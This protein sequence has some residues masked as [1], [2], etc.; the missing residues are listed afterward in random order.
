[1]PSRF[2]LAIGKVP[3]TPPKK[4]RN[5]IEGIGFGDP[6]QRQ[7]NF[8]TH[9]GLVNHLTGAEISLMTADF[10]LSI[11]SLPEGPGATI[12]I[13]LTCSIEDAQRLLMR[14]L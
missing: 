13:N 10:N 11:N 5:I 1:M 4:K 3:K 8:L 14:N 7:R 2:D 9:L 12:N 6:V